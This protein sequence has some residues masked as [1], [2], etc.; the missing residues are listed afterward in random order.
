[1]FDRSKNKK[2]G[3]ILPE[4]QGLPNGFRAGFKPFPI[5]DWPGVAAV[6]LF[7]STIAH[8]QEALRM[9][10]AGAEIAEQQKN[11]TEHNYYNLEMGPVSL[12]FQSV[13]GV[14]LTD[15]VN[16]TKTNRESD[17][18]LKPAMNVAAF[19][20]ISE[21]N[22]LFFSTGIGYVKYI[23]TAGNDHLSITPDSNLTFRMYVGD[24][25]ISFH[26]R[27]SITENI[28]QNP[29][30]SGTSNFNQY[31]NTVGTTVD[32][33]LNK[34]V[35]TFGYD[36]DMVWYPSSSYSYSDHNSHLFN[37]QA[38]FQLN[39]TTTAG[40]QVG[41]GLTDYNPNSGPNSLSDNTHF[42]VGPFYQAQLTD[43]I[44]ATASIGYVTYY[45]SGNG[46]AVNLPAENGGYA[47]L[48]LTHRVNRWLDYSL[49]GGR[50]F[51]ASA[52]TDLLDLYYANW[53]ANWHFIRYF[54]FS[55]SFT[56]QHGNSSGG[57]VEIFNQYI[58]GAGFNYQI[59]KKLA[60]SIS[61]GYS[62]KSSD[63]AANDYFENML[64]LNFIYS[65]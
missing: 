9:S 10:T 30:V 27:F 28:Q 64:V 26:D 20:P 41:G 13:M 45:F 48:T 4:H 62:Q 25:V 14:E 1:L 57:T 47:D 61:Y 53:N 52:G 17:M 16:Y 24:F 33:D 11:S 65:F 60:A 59:T 23:K 8:G 35:I 31:E 43:Y 40:L 22:S 32:W 56:Y 29:T 21:N 49:S 58:A 34:L 3:P 2:T 51:T 38:A 18:A 7:V 12:R 46:S 42:S 37:A 39:A 6:L 54:S 5:A 19:W 44:K 15:N 36:Y 50:S 55:T 63:V